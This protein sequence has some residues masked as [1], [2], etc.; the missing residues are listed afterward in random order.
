MDTPLADRF[1]TIEAIAIGASAGGIDALQKILA[2]LPRNY[3]LPIIVV[4]HLADDRESR[5]AELFSRLVAMPVREAADKEEIVLGTV[6]FAGSGYHLSVESDRSFSLSCELPVYYS[7]PSIDVMMESAAHVYGPAL[8]GILLTGASQD[9][10]EGMAQI[11][12]RGGLTVVQ[13]PDEAQ[14]RTMP[15]AALDL[16]TPD[17]ILPLQGIG[18]LLLKLENIGCNTKS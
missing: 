4:L 6:Y 13:D 9:G 18:E 1:A 10:A 17:L 3:R 8:V 15:R 7:R 2:G 16:M 11:A 12:E 5:L 14:I